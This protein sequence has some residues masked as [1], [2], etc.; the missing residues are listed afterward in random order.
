MCGLVY[1]QMLRLSRI[2]SHLHTGSS[3]QDMLQY[4][5]K[6][7]IEDLAC[8]T[9]SP[10]GQTMVSASGCGR[11]A[12]H[13]WNK[14]SG[15]VGLGDCFC[16][17][18]SCCCCFFREPGEVSFSSLSSAVGDEERTEDVPCSDLVMCTQCIR[19]LRNDRV[20]CRGPYT[21]VCVCVCL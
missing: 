15:Q 10:D 1:A 16:R 11:H 19:A 9:L 14:D 13:V 7:H 17:C 20:T 8:A 4:K 18:S 12:I 2:T 3:A 6:R 5:P 21:C